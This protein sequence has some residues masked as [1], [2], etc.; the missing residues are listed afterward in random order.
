MTPP[1]SRRTLIKTLAAALVLPTLASRMALAADEKGEALFNGKDLTGWEGDKSL[2]KVEDGVIVGDSPGIKHNQFLATTRTF[3][4]FR[5]DLEMRLKGD[6]GNSGIQFRSKRAEGSTE[7]V[8]YQA[9]AG[10]GYWGSIY[11]ESRRRKFLIQPDTKDLAA[12]LKKGDWNAYTIV[13]DGPKIE[14]SLN[15]KKMVTYREEDDSVAREGFIALQVHSGG[16]TRVEF[17]NIR[18]QELP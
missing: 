10:E 11:D 9:D 7:V 17:R 14:L 6:D 16:P 18:V 2:W 1:V 8:G 15:G 4:N 12:A 3:K 13:A 5:L